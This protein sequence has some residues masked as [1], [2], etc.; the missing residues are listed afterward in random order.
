MPAFLH[1]RVSPITFASYPCQKHR[2][3]PRSAKKHRSMLGSGEKRLSFPR[4][5]KRE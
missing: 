3:M 2:C 4:I 5:G 1:S